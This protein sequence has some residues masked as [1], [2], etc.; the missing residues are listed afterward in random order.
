MS[1]KTNP[2]RSSGAAAKNR[3]EARKF[4]VFRKF[5]GLYEA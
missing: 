1:M 2:K 4:K 5:V 3:D